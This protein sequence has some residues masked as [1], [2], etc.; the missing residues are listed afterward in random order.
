[1]AAIV[2]HG[3]DTLD[4][5]RIPVHPVNI[6]FS[7]VSDWD[8]YGVSG[9]LTWRNFIREKREP[10]NYPYTEMTYTG[11]GGVLL[12]AD[13]LGNPQ[14]YDLACPVERHKETRLFINTEAEYLAECPVCGSRFNVF[15]LTGHPVSGE[16]AAKGY[17]LRRYR[18]ETGHVGTYIIVRN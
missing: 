4:D 18:V 10:S 15:S 12:V 11:F 17:A 2:L 14:A 13:V 3:C 7:T 1:M 6:S 5:D 9:A 16:A 8:I